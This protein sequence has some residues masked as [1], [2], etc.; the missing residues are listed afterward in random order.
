[1]GRD[2]AAMEVAGTTLARRVGNVLS[3][4][5][6]PCLEVGSGV[7]GLRPILDVEQRGPLVALAKASVWFSQHER[8]GIRHVLTLAC[9]LPLIT[10]ALSDGWWSIRLIARSSQSWA[11]TPAACA[12]WTLE[13]LD[14]ATRAVAEGATA[15]QELVQIAAPDFVWPAEWVHVA[16]PEV[17]DDVDTPEDWQRIVGATGSGTRTADV[18]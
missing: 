6:S 4:V 10:P 16:S 5:A 15:M 14:L 18:A 7:S 2:K 3:E 13:D 12:R 9:D 1:M 17:F 8:S 11:A